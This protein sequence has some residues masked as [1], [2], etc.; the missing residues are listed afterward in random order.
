MVHDD[1]TGS[2]VKSLSNLKFLPT[3]MLYEDVRITQNSQNMT[4]KID[5]FIIAKKSLDQLETM[6][7]KFS[8]TSWWNVMTSY[9]ILETSNN[10]TDDTFAMFEFFIKKDILTTYLITMSGD[11]SVNIVTMNPFAKWAP[12]SWSFFGTLRTQSS[13]FLRSFDKVNICEGFYFDRTQHLNGHKIELAINTRIYHARYVYNESHIDGLIEFDQRLHLKA[14]QTMLNV[15]MKIYVS[16][17]PPYYGLIKSEKYLH[18]QTNISLVIYGT[19][20]KKNKFFDETFP[21]AFLQMLIVSH[22]RGYKTPLEKIKDYYGLWTL[23]SLFLVM[24]ITFVVIK[25]IN[26]DKSFSFV[27]FEMLRFLINTSIHTKIAATSHKIFFS[28]VSNEGMYLEKIGRQQSQIVCGMS[29]L[30][31]KYKHCKL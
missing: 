21:F 27:A 4:I 24:P 18:E 20:S 31:K 11:V 26:S 25:F 8:N 10:Q 23:L 17:S 3:I 19:F 2:I 13:L 15:T 6:I 5:A 16:S 28:N 12:S 9:F 1:D 29:K 22:N 7:D 14:I 30:R